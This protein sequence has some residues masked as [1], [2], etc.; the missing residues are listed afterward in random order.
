MPKNHLS[1]TVWG[2]SKPARCRGFTL[3]ELLVVIAI[4]AI[5]AAMLLPALAK[6]KEQAT[7]ARCLSNQKQLG[8]AWCM[9][10]DENANNLLAYGG[11]AIPGSATLQE[12]RGGGIWP[13][14]ITVTVPE[15]GVLRFA[16]LIKAR[17]KLGPLF[18]LCANVDTYH[19]PGDRRGKRTPGSTGW[20]F[21]SYSRMGGLNGESWGGAT[22]ITKQ[23]E[24][25]FPSRMLLFM[26]DADWRGFN[27]GCFVMNANQPAA[28]D[29]V[30]IY[31]N[32]KGT[33]AYTDGHAA[34]YKWKDATTI[35]GGRLAG[36]GQTGAFDANNLGPNDLRFVAGAYMCKEWPF[37]WLKP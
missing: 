29:P 9:Y 5:L 20:A 3:I 33:M 12:L 10:N 35:R 31:H 17:I 23:S 37:N 16:A 8:L 4:I 25:R 34:W 2:R 11:F 6:A 18:R 1:T 32:N 7:G 24:L 14:E 19:C 28:V 26:E 30:A 15:T 21:D 22:P 27:V 36:S 13:S